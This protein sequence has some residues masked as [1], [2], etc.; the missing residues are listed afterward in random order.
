MRKITL[1]SCIGL[2]LF[3]AVML[4]SNPPTASGSKNAQPAVTG[5]S[6]PDSVLKFVQKTCMDC[7]SA[8]GN[9]LAKGKVNFSV[10]DNYDQAKK[11]DKAGAICK[12]LTKGGM[13]TGKWRK[14]NPDKVPTKADI[15]MMCR[16][17]VSLQK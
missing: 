3:I 10:W 17:A 6:L 8:D 7:H 2:G 4:V 14:N 11:A 9:F 13:P 15:D 16:W 12:E 1:I 5:T